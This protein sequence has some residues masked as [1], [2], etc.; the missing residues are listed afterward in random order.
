MIDLTEFKKLAEPA[1]WKRG[2]LYFE[3]GAVCS[4]EDDGN[5]HWEAIVSGNDDYEVSVDIQFGHVQEWSCDCP[6]DGDI[7]KHVV[8]MV[9]AIRDEK[10]TIPINIKESTPQP[11]TF[12]QLVAAVS[13]DE[14]RNFVKQYAGSD[15]NFKRAFQVKFAEK[16][17]AG[18]KV[19]YAKLIAQSLHSGMGR[20]GF[21]EYSHTRKAFGTVFDLLNK[22]NELLNQKNFLGTWL[23]AS[24]VI[25]QVSEVT[26]SVDDSNGVIGE[27]IEEAFNLISELADNAE[28]PIPLKEQMFDWHKTEYPKDK[29][30]NYGDDNILDSMV[31]LAEVTNRTGEIFPILDSAIRRTSSDYELVNLLHHKLG[32]LKSLDR[33]QEYN[34]LV[35]SNLQHPEFRKI[36][37]AELLEQKSYTEAEKLIGEGIRIS[38]AQMRG[39][40][41]QHWKEQLLEIYLKT[42]QQEK[43]IVL[44]RELFYSSNRQYYPLL[45]KTIGPEKWPEELAVIISNLKKSRRDWNF[46]FELYAAEQMLPELLQLI[47]QYAEFR[48]LN[49]YEALLLPKFP[50][51]IMKLYDQ[52]CQSYA[53]RANARSDYHE[54]A[55]MLKHVQKL[56]GG[57]PLTTR[58]LATF[59]EV[60]KRRPAMMDELRNLN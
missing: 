10:K 43:Y 46:L 7:C 27:S 53:A 37:L 6:Y 52:V 57:K 44:L 49:T 39:G 35:T 5:G 58:L 18:G 16:N 19:Q 56:D 38:E 4:L 40:T 15:K 50:A 42:N 25:E 36:K 17:P 33:M 11:K 47:G 24:A 55:S 28:V 51:E 60:Y 13:N 48:L 29:Y 23:I 9:L 21:I 3:D 1:I 12:E 22:A 8:A 59:R 26:G 20:Y 2:K 45:K 41:T 54:L 31:E 34:E 30:E 14:L 32:L